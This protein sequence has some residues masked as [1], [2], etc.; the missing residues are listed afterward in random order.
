VLSI[1]PNW[2]WTHSRTTISAET[3]T[4]QR[5]PGCGISQRTSPTNSVLVAIMYPKSK[6]LRAASNATAATSAFTGGW[7]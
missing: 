1:T 7:A 6:M 3:T 2:T 4:D 5:H